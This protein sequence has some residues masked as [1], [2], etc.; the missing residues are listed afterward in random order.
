MAI[1]LL[2]FY[3]IALFRISRH[4][5][6]KNGG[7]D[8][9]FVNNRAS[10]ASGV[11]LS[12][13]VS[14]VGASA[15]MGVVGMAF[16][17]GT[18]AFWWL[19][20]GA[21]GL[22]MLAL[23]LATKVRDSGCITLPQMSAQLLGPQARPLM[24]GII[25]VA[26]TAILAAQFAAL[27]AIIS[28]LTG[29]SSNWCLPISFALVVVHTFGGQ[30]AI[31]NTD[32][33]QSYLLL[34]GLLVLLGGLSWRN[35]GWLA[36]TRLEAV[37]AQFTV[38]D[39]LRYAF[40]VGGN[41]LVCPMLFGRVYCARDAASARLGVLLGALGLVVCSVVIV[42]VGLA[43]HGVVAAATPADSVLVSAIAQAMPAWLG[44]LVYLAL[45]SAIV[46]SADS[47][48]VTSS[49]VLCYDLLKSSDPKTGKV[50]VFILGAAGLSLTLF[51]KSILGN[52]FL[53]YDIY[54][55]GVVMPV[56]VAL[57]YNKWR[58]RR[59]VFCLLGIASGGALGVAAAYWGRPDYSYLGMALS[60]ALTFAG[61]A[62]WPAVAR[63]EAP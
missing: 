58:V 29:W 9:F 42:S 56:F 59:P 62:E 60:A 44:V 23:L 37:N 49:T 53:A 38:N 15:T 8:A 51:N 32:R 48:L 2:C 36:A 12:L 63:T 14:C 57:I 39:L 11:A 24:S 3:A 5:S 55:A 52:L 27:T 31:F 18:P 45:V 13:V 25:V 19:G 40:V 20:A 7:S 35:P 4:I 10:S 16:T 21:V 30:A 17:L 43:A 61:I 6:R 47:C 34:G 41:Y 33:F 54:V 46:S 50:C 26:W 1:A 28:S 22:T